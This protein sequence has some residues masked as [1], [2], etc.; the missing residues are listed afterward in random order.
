MK[1]LVQKMGLSSLFAAVTIFAVTFPGS[2]TAQLGLTNQTVYNQLNQSGGSVLN[3][4]SGIVLTTIID[5]T[6]HIYFVEAEIDVERIEPA[7]AGLRTTYIGLTAGVWL[8]GEFFF[9]GEIGEWATEQGSFVTATNT[10]TASIPAA[11]GHTVLTVPVT[12]P[13]EQFL[14]VDDA[15]YVIGF[16]PFG[17]EVVDGVTNQLK[18]RIRKTD[19]PVSTESVRSFQVAGF[20]FEQGPS[21]DIAPKAKVVI[22][23]LIYTAGLP[24]LTIQPVNSGGEPKMRVSWSTR[25]PGWNLQYDPDPAFSGPEYI[26]MSL[27]LQNANS[28]QL[29][30]PLADSYYV[31]MSFEPTAP[32]SR[33]MRLEWPFFDFQPIYLEIRSAFS[34]PPIV[35]LP[36][37]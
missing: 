6:V 17:Y 19:Q 1:K 14:P 36:E 18:V 24:T 26:D 22:N 34:G 10:I 15:E 4:F 29:T 2:V 13:R 20:P 21:Y 7:P 16:F 12:F 23:K 27:A 11:V 35:P 5:E 32:F 9:S 25:H 8:A 28:V 33:F 37:P 31:D 30:S 3:G